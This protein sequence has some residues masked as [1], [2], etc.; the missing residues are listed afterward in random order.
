MSRRSGKCNSLL[1]ICNIC[2]SSAAPNHHG[3]KHPL[4]RVL[5]A[6]HTAPGSSLG[7]RQ[8]VLEPLLLLSSCAA[9]QVEDDWK[10]VVRYGVSLCSFFLL[11]PFD[12]T[13]LPYLPLSQSDA[14]GVFLVP[15][16]LASQTRRYKRHLG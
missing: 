2:T 7:G 9:K 11:L 4:T 1:H 5:L 14:D 16:P 12:Q 6:A 13:L 10:L 8:E 15:H 3:P